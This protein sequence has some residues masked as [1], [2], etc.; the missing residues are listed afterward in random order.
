MPFFMIKSYDKL[1]IFI[2]DTGNIN[3]KVK[4]A[5]CNNIFALKIS[6]ML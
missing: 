6:S 4:K 2:L 5:H 3:A 1:L